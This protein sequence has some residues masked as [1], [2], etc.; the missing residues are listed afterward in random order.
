VRRVEA[1]REAA[2]ASG[3]HLA[4]LGDLQGPKIRIG[5]FVEGSVMLE[6][7]GAFTIDAAWPPNEGHVERVGTNYEPLPREVAPGDRLVLGDGLI[8]LEV[9]RSGGTEVACR[10]IQGGELSG[11]K[12]V[13]KR[14]GGLTAP[15]ITSRDE[16]DIA[17]AAELELDYV[18]VSFP[19]SA[20][21]IRRARR[22]AEERA[23][24]CGVV[25]KIERAEVV[26]DPACL[27]E[28][29]ASADAVM[30]ARGDLGIEIGDAALMGVQKRIIA[31]CRALNREVITATQM[32]ESMVQS[33]VPTRAEVMD[34][35]NAV[36][37]GTDAVM[38]SAETAVGRYPR[39]AVEAMERVIRGAEGTAHFGPSRELDLR[40]REIDES[41]AL[42][43]MTMARHLDDVRALACV[44]TSGN[45]PRLL[46]R[47]RSRLPIYAMSDRARTLSRV[48]LFHSVQPVWLT[49]PAGD[50]AALQAEALGC[51]QRAGAVTRGDRVILCSGDAHGVPGATNTVKVVEVP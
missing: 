3:R 38:L 16:A 15:A 23:L 43:A 39:A 1:I 44:T 28:V 34:V 19:R 31:R 51:L 46:S 18:A 14:G 8:E 4:V 12:G 41:I 45:T 7:G 27:D 2:R 22:L 49:V 35:A 25:A 37:D 26:A 11:N 13:N 33:P 36:L 30:V 48:A 6:R 29:I 9:A 32:M 20:E 42:A 5:D 40:L 50:G 17:L 47:F 10:V 21:D 24:E